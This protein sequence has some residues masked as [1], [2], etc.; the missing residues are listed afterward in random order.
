[1]IIDAAKSITRIS[2]NEEYNAQNYLE[3]LDYMDNLYIFINHLQLVVP[4]DEVIFLP[5]FKGKYIVEKL[6]IASAD[7]ENRMKV[8][9][10]HCPLFLE[11]DTLLKLKKE[12]STIVDEIEQVS[13]IITFYL[14]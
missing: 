4:L 14:Y 11:D 10:V 13:D 5:S 2:D 12:L 8:F 1:M 7:K 9:K 3:S 6:G